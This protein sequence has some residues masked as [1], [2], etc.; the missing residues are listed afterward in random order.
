[1]TGYETCLIL[2]GKKNGFFLKVALNDSTHLN[3]MAVFLWHALWKQ[4]G[5]D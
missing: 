3:F 4:A 5:Q 2:H 1:M